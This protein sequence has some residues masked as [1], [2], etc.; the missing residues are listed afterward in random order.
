MGR[1]PASSRIRF[2]PILLTVTALVGCWQQSAIREA[3]ALRYDGRL[4]FL[5]P[6]QSARAAIRI[7]IADSPAARTK[8]LMGRRLRDD[9][10]GMLFILDFPEP[11]TFWM[12]NTPDSLDMIFVAEDGRVFD[13][14][15]RTRPQSDQTYSSNGPASYVVEVKG[16]FAERVGIDQSCRIRWQRN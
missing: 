10:E 3:S 9:R 15:E 7:E 16:G 8:G 14:V 13:I 2:G 11:P 4:E 5:C 12:H 6:G 1:L